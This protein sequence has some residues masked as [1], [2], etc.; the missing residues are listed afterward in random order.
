[1]K[2]GREAIITTCYVK[3]QNKNKSLK[4]PKKVPKEN[5]EE[6]S[7]KEYMLASENKTCPIFEKFVNISCFL[8]S[9]FID[10]RYTKSNITTVE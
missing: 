9:P 8:L 5:G 4:K 1:M 2:K 6:R 7:G 3:E 10:N